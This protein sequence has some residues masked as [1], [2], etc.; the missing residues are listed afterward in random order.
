MNINS[1][2][3][4]RSSPW[5][6]FLLGVVLA[7]A[8]PAASLLLT[9]ATLHPVSGPV[10][11]AASLLIRDGQIISLGITISGSADQTLDLKGQHV[12]PGLIAPNTILGLQEIDSIRAT[13]DTTESGEYTPDVYSW[14]AVNPDSELI[15][16]ARANGFTHVQPIPLGTSVSGHSA[17]I[18]LTGWTIEDMA[19]KRDTGL[20]VF[21]PS[22]QF[23]T[24]PKERIRN[25]ENWKS[26]EDQVKARDQKLQQLDEFFNEAEAYAK[27]RTAAATTHAVRTVPAWE[28]M[29]PILR[30]EVPVFLHAD[31]FRQI[32][33]AVDWVV[34]RQ[35]RA[36]LAG[37]RD[38][39]R[40][41]GL[42]A[43][44]QIP[45]AYEHLFTPPVRDIDP[46]DAQ[47]AVPAVLARAGVQVSFSEGTAT[48]GASNIRNLPY[49]AAQARAFGL[50]YEEALRGLTLY[51][52][53][54]LGLDARLGTLEP[55]KEATFFIADGDILDVRTHV[56]RMWISG[57]EV[58]LESRH[59]RL[60]D[61]Y[62]QRPKSP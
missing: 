18:A 16:V 46:Y 12:F 23:D 29:L 3:R 10:L 62:R 14:K 40:L 54:I 21:W 38:A 52:A 37:G 13:R 41:A 36:V 17:A 56:K 19:I 30:R 55:G 22:F 53:R 4:C 2:R 26:L 8:S 59:T 5:A 9:N 11:A 1:L 7:G 32:Q 24:T 49:A 47:F 28:A 51:P 44:H 42:L 27:A 20:H 50:P 15:P 48:F 60:Y 34:R 58:S 57:Q 25:K 6:T 35:Y 61:R 45:V 43:T 31:E 39:G 33:S